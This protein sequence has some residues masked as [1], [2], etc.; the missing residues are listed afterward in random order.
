MKVAHH[1]GDLFPGGIRH[2][3]DDFFSDGLV[4]GPAEC[5]D[6]GLVEQDGALGIGSKLPGKITNPFLMKIPCASLIL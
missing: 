4:I 6:R 1:A 5:F 2:N 3:V